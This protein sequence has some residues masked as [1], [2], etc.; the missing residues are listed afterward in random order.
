MT[1]EQRGEA[2]LAAIRGTIR[3]E[4]LIE[5]VQ[6]L[7]RLLDGDELDPMAHQLGNATVAAHA[8]L[9]GLL[10]NL[11]PATAQGGAGS[12]ESTEE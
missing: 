2:A 11:A 5:A 12:Q 6:P 3:L 10:D 9:R 1:P 7:H 4:Q 8:A